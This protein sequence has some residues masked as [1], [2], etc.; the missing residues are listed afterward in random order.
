[1][2]QWGG[3][4]RGDGEPREGTAGCWVRQSQFVDPKVD[5]GPSHGLR[6]CAENQPLDS[7][8]LFQGSGACHCQGYRR[9]PQNACDN[10]TP[11]SPVPWVPGGCFLELMMVWVG[12]TA[13]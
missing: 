10:P 5:N 2:Q 6:P 4:F 9:A 12:A 11:M 7:A 8:L 3:T 13:V 1:M